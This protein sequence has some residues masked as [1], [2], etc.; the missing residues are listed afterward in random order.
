MIL[1]SSDDKRLLHFL[2]VGDAWPDVQHRVVAGG[3]LP[4]DKEVPVFVHDV[5]PALRPDE[6]TPGALV[7][8]HLPVPVGKQVPTKRAQ[9]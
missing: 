6:L 5:L 8:D 3:E 4:Y 7:P 9:G 2:C 1:E